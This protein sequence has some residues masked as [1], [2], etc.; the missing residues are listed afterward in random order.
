MD[1]PDTYTLFDFISYL[2]EF[3]FYKFCLTN[4]FCVLTTHENDPSYPLHSSKYQGSTLICYFHANP[5]L[6]MI[7]DCLKDKTI[8]KIFRHFSVLNRV[9]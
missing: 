1:R 8:L 6:L 9:A 3:G 4:I 2:C 7:P 5:I